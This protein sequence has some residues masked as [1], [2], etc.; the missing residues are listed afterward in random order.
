VGIAPKSTDAESVTSALMQALLGFT[1]DARWLR[2]ARKQP[3][4]K[5]RLDLER[6]GGRTPAAALLGPSSPASGG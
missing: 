3:D 5:G 6:D 1:S 4:L 2:H